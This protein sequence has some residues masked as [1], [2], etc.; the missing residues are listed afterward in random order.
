MVLYVTQYAELGAPCARN[1]D[2]E[3]SQLSESISVCLGF[4]VKTE[5]NHISMQTKALT[6]RK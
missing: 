4:S 2:E 1:E 3:G 6:A 5:M